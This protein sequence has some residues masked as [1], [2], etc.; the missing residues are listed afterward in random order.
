MEEERG[1]EK[2]PA[3]ENETHKAIVAEK[4]SFFF[5]PQNARVGTSANPILL[6][7]VFSIVRIVQKVCVH[8]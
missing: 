8:E 7:F 6:V 3:R 4:V 2:A 1:T 5:I